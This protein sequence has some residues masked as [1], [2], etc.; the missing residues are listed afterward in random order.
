MKKI[1]I[2]HGWGGSPNEPLHIWLKKELENKGHEVCVPE[3]PNPEYPKIDAWVGKLQE[4]IEKPHEDTILVGH[5][6]GCQTILRYLETLPEK[7]KVAGV[8]L[9]APWIFLSP[10]SIESNEAK[11]IAKPWLE[12]KMPEPSVINRHINNNEFYTIF[13]DN[14]PDVPFEENKEWFEKTYY[15]KVIVEHEKGHFSED[16]GVIKLPS[17]LNIISSI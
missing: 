7:S 3:M 15:P 16:A 17:A 12:T 13:S 1:Y 11:E 5:S 4:V 2:V 9:I 10:E 14:D 6:I 8:V